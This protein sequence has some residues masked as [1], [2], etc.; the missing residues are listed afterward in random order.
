VI[1]FCDTSALVKLYIAESGTDAVEAQVDASEFVSFCRITWAECASALA[2]RARETPKDA[3]AI[4]RAR[5]RFESEWSTCLVL[6]VTQELVELAGDYSEAFALRAYDAVQL[7]AVQLLHREF[8][9][10]VRFA[11]FDTRLHKAS[12]ILGIDVM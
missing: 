8:P 7:A 2:R 12:R 4:T 9:G 3:D 11:C 10:E 1:L 6:E 5:R